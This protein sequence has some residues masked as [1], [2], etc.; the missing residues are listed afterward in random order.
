[1]NVFN[2]VVLLVKNVSII[3]P[4]LIVI[5]GIFLAIR[6]LPLPLTVF[7]LLKMFE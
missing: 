5:R 3:F 6:R 1:M 4:E 2:F 7:L